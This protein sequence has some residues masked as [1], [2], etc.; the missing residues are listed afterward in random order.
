MK[1]ASGPAGSGAIPEELA[2]FDRWT[3]DADVAKGA[4]TLKKNQVQQG[5]RK[6]SVEGSLT[7]GT[8]PKVSFVTP[9]SA[10]EKR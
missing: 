1:P 10:A 5:A 7:F 3:A 6:G 2:R 8:P 4:I 9:G